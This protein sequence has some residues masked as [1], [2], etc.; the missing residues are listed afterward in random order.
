ME[1]WLGNPTLCNP[2]AGAVIA[3]NDAE[4]LAGGLTLIPAQGPQS[5]RCLLHLRLRR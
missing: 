5:Y 1:F 4:R 3:P 2:G